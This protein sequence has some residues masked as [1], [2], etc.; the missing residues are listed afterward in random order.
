[1]AETVVAS[2]AVAE[3]AGVVLVAVVVVSAVGA[4][5]RSAF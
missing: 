1:M 3:E 2:A 5:L 4:R